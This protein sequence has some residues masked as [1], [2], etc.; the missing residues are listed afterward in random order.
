MPSG[1]EFRHRT[2]T[3]VTRDHDTAEYTCTRATPYK[4]T[5]MLYFVGMFRRD[6]GMEGDK[7]ISSKS[8]MFSARLASIFVLDMKYLKDNGKVLT[9]Y[10]HLFVSS[11]S[12][13]QGLRSQPPCPSV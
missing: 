11:I 9:F 13:S 3:C 12:L 6:A 1:Q 8:W 4:R 10:D 2:R 5:M 7:E